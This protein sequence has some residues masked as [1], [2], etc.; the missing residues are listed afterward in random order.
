MSYESNL[1][2]HNEDIASSHLFKCEDT[3]VNGNRY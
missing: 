2:N 3:R 1:R